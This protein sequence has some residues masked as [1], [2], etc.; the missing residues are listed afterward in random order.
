MVGI[1]SERYAFV[2]QWLDP[3]SE[4]L[5]KYQVFWYPDTSEA[6]MYDIKNRRKMLHRTRL[7]ELKTADFYLGNTVCIY[8]RQLHLLEYGDSF[9]ADRLSATQEQTLAMVKP[10]ALK[11]FG[12]ILG[13]VEAA[14]FTVG[15]LRMCQLTPAI[16]QGFYAVHADRPFFGPLTKFMSS[17]RIVAME[18]VAPGAIR[19]WRDLLG[20]T[21]SATARQ[22]APSSLRA[23]FG[24][25]NTRNACHGSD[26]PETAAQES[27]FFFNRSIGRCC[28]GSNTTLALIKPHA[29]RSRRMGE[30]VQAVQQNFDVTAAEMFT[31]DAVNAGEFLEVYRGV[32]PSAEYAG[33]IDELTSGAFLALEVSSQDGSSPVEALRHFCGPADPDMAKILRPGSLR[34]L[35][36]QNKVQ[37][38]VHCT[39]LEEDGDLETKYFFDIMQPS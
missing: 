33:L 22:E 9:T 20:P 7:P 11:N 28:S 25:D 23:R 30:I 10:D 4:I 2:A 38:A 31:F 16:A 13:A 29:V 26:A 6:E 21:N 24:S 34:A 36:G 19:K 18:L 39:D 14:G 12:A 27:A 17:G 8:S 37:N 1:I 32:L 3:A 5:W 35:Y 15:R